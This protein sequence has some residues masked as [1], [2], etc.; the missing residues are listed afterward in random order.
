[1]DLLE[2]EIAKYERRV[3]K[4]EDNP[5]PKMMK[6][7][8]LLYELQRDYYKQLLNEWQE[9]R[10]FAYFED[11]APYRVLLAMG[12]RPIWLEILGDYLPRQEVKEYLELA[13]AAGFP[14]NA[15]DRVQLSAGVFLAGARGDIP[16]PRFSVTLQGDCDGI[17]QVALWA[18]RR[19]KIPFMG[20]D[21]PFGDD[22]ESLKYMEAQIRDMIQLVEEKVPGAHKLDEEKLV[23]YQEIE[24]QRQHVEAEILEIA[25]AKP[26]PLAGR[27]ALRIPPWHICDDPRVVDYY[28]E[29][30]DELKAKTS[31]KEG[32]AIEEKARV[33]WLVSAPFFTDGFRFL[34]ERGIAVPLYEVGPGVPMVRQIG[35][36]RQYGRHLTPLE[37]EAAR[38]VTPRWNGPL[39]RR[40]GDIYAR[41]KQ[42]G[43]DGL[44]HFQQ[45]G[46]Q[47]CIAHA[48]VIADKAEREL[49]IPSLEV[50]GYCQD[51]ERHNEVEFANK[52]SSFADWLL[53]RKKPDR[54]GGS[55]S[56]K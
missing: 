41:C 39:E 19:F 4:I 12:L 21:V 30:R 8:K 40:W 49:G 18:G 17:T 14:D 46:C 25:K 54:G 11:V 42:Y 27:D 1:M 28:R 38:C 53:E 26:C 7:N 10:P 13:R 6:S 20:L 52:V 3:K 29:M 31:K 33:M 16:A 43:I 44:V 24:K 45:P 36:D 5:D 34:E 37:E 55:G 51:A 32:I 9:G 47:T 15:C 35:D 22:W 23:E 50:E 2:K 56:P 48:R